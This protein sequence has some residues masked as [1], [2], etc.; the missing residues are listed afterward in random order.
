MQ[1]ADRKGMRLAWND[2]KRLRMPVRFLT[3]LTR[4]SAPEYREIFILAVHG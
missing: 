3:E 2:L 1:D 4:F